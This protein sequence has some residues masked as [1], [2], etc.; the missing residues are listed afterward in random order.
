MVRP[1]IRVAPYFQHLAFG[2][3]LSAS[4]C[5]VGA[6]LRGR[7]MLA[8]MVPLDEVGRYTLGYTLGMGML[9]IVTSINDA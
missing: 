1:Q 8:K 7:V 9:M 4:P 2:L 3:Q 6:G 5:R